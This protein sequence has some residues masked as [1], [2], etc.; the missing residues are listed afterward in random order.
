[1]ILETI[2]GYIKD[3]LTYDASLI[4]LGRLNFDKVTTTGNYIVLDELVS[5]PLG[6]NYEFDG[7]LEKETI[8]VPMS[9]DFTID[10][11]G[12]TAR[13]NAVKL[14]ATQK[15]QKSYELQRDAG[16]KVQHAQSLTDLKALEGSQFNDRYQVAISVI[17]NETVV[18][19]TLRIDTAEV[20]IINNK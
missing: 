17:Y 4:V 18:I 13:A 14:L 3:L 12:S 16:I 9:G 6:T 15:G 5:T 10:F 11:H 7:T 2:A 1:M 8:S 19:D 20:T